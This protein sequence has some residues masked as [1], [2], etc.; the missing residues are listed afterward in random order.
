[1]PVLP[2]YSVH[3]ACHASQAAMHCRRSCD[4][5]QLIKEGGLFGGRVPPPLEA[6]WALKTPAMAA[7]HEDASPTRSGVA[8]QLEKFGLPSWHVSYWERIQARLARLW[9]GICREAHIS[10]PTQEVSA[11]LWCAAGRLACQHACGH[12]PR[13]PQALQLCA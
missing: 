2:D 13:A 1:M 6:K 5:V 7:M 9:W 11:G 4:L 3:R 10:S 12:T 8:T